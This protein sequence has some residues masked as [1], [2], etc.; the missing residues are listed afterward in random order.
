MYNDNVQLYVNLAKKHKPMSKEDELACARRY[1]AG[2]QEAGDKLI[3]CSMMFALKQAY[4]YHKRFPHACI[5]DLLMEANMG[6]LLARKKFDPDLGYRFTTYAVHWIK[7]YT[8]NYC[9]RYRNTIHYG[10]TESERAL[11]SILVPIVN[12]VKMQNP[13]ASLSEAFEIA[14]EELPI[15]ASV[16]REQY[17]RLTITDRSLS[18]RVE[19]DSCTLLDT[20]PSDDPA[21][22]DTVDDNAR[23]EAIKEAMLIIALRSKRDTEFHIIKYRLLAEE[24]M[25][26][27]EIGKRLSLSRETVRKKERKLIKDIQNKLSED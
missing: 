21:P 3:L 8:L 20:L 16:V 23:I 15:T 5:E 18:D 27:R 13:Y 10:T 25:T 12:R 17:E 4:K 2:S 6:M 24:P 1:R 19:H 14:A 11:F 7:A 9:M 22:D 26:L